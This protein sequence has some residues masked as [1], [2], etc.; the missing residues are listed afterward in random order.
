MNLLGMYELQGNFVTYS[1]MPQDN[2][3]FSY[4]AVNRLTQAT[5]S[6]SACGGWC[7]E[8]GFGYDPRGDMWVSSNSGVPLAGNTPKPNIFNSANNQMNGQSYD[9]SGNQTSLN[10]N[11]ADLRCD[12][13]GDVDCGAASFGG[14]T[15]TLAYDGVESAF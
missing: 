14:G 5:D 15:E 8:R 4:D 6:T 9:A 3:N 10:G 11:T 12:G 13:P 1:S 7:W 2:D